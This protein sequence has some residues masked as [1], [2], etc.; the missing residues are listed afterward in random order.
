[1]NQAPIAMGLA[2][3]SAYFCGTV[4][5]Q[6]FP[7]KPIR[8]ITSEA[9]GGN[10]SAARIYAQGMTGPLQQPVI[11]ENRGG[12]A[13]VEMVAKALPD[14]YTLFLGGGFIWIA[15][16]IQKASY[17]PVKDFSPVSLTTTS[18]NV[19]V[20]HASVAAHS[21]RELI[22]L[23]KAKPGDLNYA[24]GG[25][26]TSNHLAA[27][28][29]RYMTG[30]NMVRINYKGSGPALTSLLGGQVQ[31][32]FST[33]TSAAPHFKAGKLRGLAVSSN[34]PT[35][36]APDLP[37]IATSGVPGYESASVGTVFAPA[38]TPERAI[39]RLNDELLRV[40]NTADVKAK[41]FNAGAEVVASSP[42]QLA[43]YMKS[44]M[45]RMRVVVKDAGIRME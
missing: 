11:V 5:A 10:D 21:V 13:A 42:E 14:G 38:R 41:F 43:D 25:T 32:M 40:L 33:T 3:V 4:H 30:V 45:A 1:M 28:L 24:T 39:R 9:G 8:I 6:P 36:L 26:A 31:L 18:P 23:A 27:E 16:L 15:P 22:A 19:L 35:S 34:K 17:D 2:C 20:V 37:T 29:F 44:D 12:L 7:G